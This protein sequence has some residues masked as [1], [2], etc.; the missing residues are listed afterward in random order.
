MKHAL[1]EAGVPL[2]LK[3]SPPAKGKK[4]RQR[5]ARAARQHVPGQLIAAS[6]SQLPELDPR[7]PSPQ[8][9]S[10][11]ASHAG[12]SPKYTPPYPG[13]R[14]TFELDELITEPLASSGDPLEMSFRNRQ[15]VKK[16]LSKYPVAPGTV[17]SSIALPTQEAGWLRRSEESSAT[18][19]GG[20]HPAAR[21]L[22]KFPAAPGTVY[23]S[24]ALPINASEMPRSSEDA[25]STSFEDRYLMEWKL[26]NFP[27]ASGIGNSSTALPTLNL[28]GGWLDSSEDASLMSPEDRYLMNWKLSSSPFATGIVNSSTALPTLESGWLDSSEEASSTTSEGRHPEEW[29]HSRFP[30][31]TGV[32]YSSIALSM[33]NESVARRTWGEVSSTS[34][35]RAER[36]A[37][38]DQ[39]SSTR[40]PSTAADPQ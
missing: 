22:S 18:S 3:F 35:Q 12:D 25:S 7:A 34:A 37:D 20:R 29:T 38:S 33:A 13:G 27:S 40:D 24:A 6:A 19:S 11:T 4:G 39:M 9:T 32:A 8:A 16:T 30:A 36:D 1:L 5:F 10:A 15:Q 14:D 28:E 21:T 23:S 31:T 17:Y 2:R 26:S